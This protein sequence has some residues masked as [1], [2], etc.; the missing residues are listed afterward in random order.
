[1]IHARA[2]RLVLVV[3]DHADTRALYLA[4]LQDEGMLGVAAGT[5]MAAMELIRTARFDAIVI[6]R[7]LPDM[8]GLELCAK[9]REQEGGENAALIILSGSSPDRDDDASYDA[10]LVKPVIPDQ[11]LAVLRRVFAKRS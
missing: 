4:V 8:E 3:E 11:L 10:Y 2:G 7:G 6:D 9:L 1:M 5:G